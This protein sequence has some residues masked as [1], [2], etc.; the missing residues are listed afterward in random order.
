MVRAELPVGQFLRTFEL[1]VPVE[2][3]QVHVPKALA[4]RPR[5][6]PI[7][8]EAPQSQGGRRVA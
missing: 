8:L 6:I 7:Q 4:V 1:G 5:S 2:A 3:E